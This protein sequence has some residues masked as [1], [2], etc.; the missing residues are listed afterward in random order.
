MTKKFFILLTAFVFALSAFSMAFADAKKTKVKKSAVQTNQLVTLLPGSDAVVTID[1]Q[2]LMK[3]ALPQILATN[4]QIISGM[5]AKLDEI[6]S[7]IGI[8][9]RQFEQ[10]AI[11]IAYKKVSA[12]ETDF[13]PVILARGK[14]NSSAFLGVAKL[15]SNGK[16]RQ[17]KIGNRTIYVFSPKEILQDNRPQNANPKTNKIIDRLTKSLSGEIALTSYDNNTLVIGTVARLQETFSPKPRVSRELLNLASRKP[18]AIIGFGANTPDGV[19]QFVKLEYDELGKNL[20][21]IRQ[22]YGAFDFTNGNAV[23]SVT[24]KSLTAGDAQ[25]LEET[26]SGLQVV[27]KIFLGGARG[28]DKKLY[29]KL[30]ENAVISRK[31]NEVMLDLQIPQTDVNA[32]VAILL[33]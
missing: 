20:D 7:K 9:L 10:L 25:S 15:G 27:G 16:Y 24:A 28:D 22:M 30:L 1:M 8:D 12:T 3:D 32:L 33:K 14:F 18:N 29:A 13:E 31:T 4:P 6:Q 11:G 21:A 5:N 23:L 19:S 2:R 17:E 26:V